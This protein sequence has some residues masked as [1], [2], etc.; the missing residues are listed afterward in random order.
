MEAE[1]VLRVD[2]KTD[3]WNAIVDLLIR[4][5]YRVTYDYQGFDKGIDV[6]L[7][8]LRKKEE[9]VLLGWS[10]WFEGELYCSPGLLNTIE[11]QFKATFQTG[12]PEIL[13]PTLIEE[14]VD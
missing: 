7:M 1:K 8:M 10:N 4:D 12:V 6:D 5:E 13:T 9:R 2:I 14:M 3:K 11:K